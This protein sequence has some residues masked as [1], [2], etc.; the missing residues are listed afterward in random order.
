MYSNLTSALTRVNHRL[1]ILSRIIPKKKL[2]QPQGRSLGTWPKFA[3]K[4]IRMVTFDVTGTLV[5]FRGTLEE[6]YL[7]AAT[8]L[9][10]RNVDSSQFANSF[11]KAYKVRCEDLYGTGYTLVQNRITGI[12]LDV[13]DLH[14]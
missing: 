13:L 9:G 6:H 1:V 11:G 7:G 8:K 4:R 12:I 2:Q 3:P 10:V 14:Y 5:S